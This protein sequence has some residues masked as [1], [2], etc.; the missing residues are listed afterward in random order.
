MAPGDVT[1]VI[2]THL[3]FDH[4]G[5]ATSKGEVVFRNATYRV[6]EADWAYFV[7]SPGAAPGAVRKLSPVKA[8]LE[9]FATQ[10]VLA[11]GLEAR[12]A[13]GHTPG[14]TIYIL[15]SGTH[16]ALLLGDVAHCTVE[17]TEPGWEFVFD[18][19]RAAA[20]VVREQITAELLDSQDPAAGAHF[21]DPQFGRLVRGGQGSQ[22]AQG[23]Q[24]GQDEKAWIF[25]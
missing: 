10:C 2:F 15:S 22:A 3:H 1:D 8:Q 13:P 20:K 6:H 18:V 21:P 16:R 25:L 5:W 24:S 9:T 19:D 14:S 4:V 11:P 17:L 23:S 7:E 12:P